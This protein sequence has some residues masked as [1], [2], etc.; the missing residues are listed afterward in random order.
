MTD[1]QSRFRVSF[2]CALF[3]AF[4]PAA[5]RGGSLGDLSLPVPG[6]MLSRLPSSRSPVRCFPRLPPFR[7]WPFCRPFAGR[8]REWPASVMAC[9]FLSGPSAAAVGC[10]S[11]RLRRLFVA[12][13]QCSSPCRESGNRRRPF[14]SSPSPFCALSATADPPRSAVQQGCEASNVTKLL[15]IFNIFIKYLHNSNLARIFAVKF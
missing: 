11:C 5:V 15:N 13:L 2:F 3:A 1:D 4:S 7:F 12:A 8:T 6:P 9:P 10:L 14:P